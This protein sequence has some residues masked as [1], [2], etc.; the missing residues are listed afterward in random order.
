[1]YE[2]YKT[3][4]KKFWHP[5]SSTAP[6]NR[7]KTLIIA[8]GDGNYITDIDGH[9]IHLRRRGVDA[10]LDVPLYALLHHLGPAVHRL[11]YRLRHL[12][13]G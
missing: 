5:M 13:P 6:G 2:K 7:E 8:K 1:M 3:A 9:R 10:Q 11:E 4:E 12:V